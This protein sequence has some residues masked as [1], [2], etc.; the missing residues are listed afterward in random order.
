MPARKEEEEEEEE[1]EGKIRKAF[2]FHFHR[3]SHRRDSRGQCVEGFPKCS[4][5]TDEMAWLHLSGVGFMFNYA[6]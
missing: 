4:K 6:G 3:V 5:V 1:E 2:Q